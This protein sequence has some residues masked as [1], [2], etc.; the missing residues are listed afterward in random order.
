MPDHQMRPLVWSL[1]VLLNFAVAGALLVQPFAFLIWVTAEHGGRGLATF[2]WAA[3]WGALLGIVIGF[4]FLLVRYV[5]GR[6]GGGR[7][8]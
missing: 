1:L 3:M 6:A 2:P 5:Y 8:A 7:T 4:G